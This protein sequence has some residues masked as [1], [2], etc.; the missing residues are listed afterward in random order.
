MPRRSGNKSISMICTVGVMSDCPA[1]ASAIGA[2]EMKVSHDPGASRGA[3][4]NCSNRLM[5]TPTPITAKPSVTMRRA[6][7]RPA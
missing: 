1:A 3:S 6:L 5:P 4:V 7:I 2:I